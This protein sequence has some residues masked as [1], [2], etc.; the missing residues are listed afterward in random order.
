MVLRLSGASNV[1]GGG[2]MT[3]SFNWENPSGTVPAANSVTVAQLNMW[4]HIVG[5]WDGT[6][7]TIYVN[8]VA[9]GTNNTAQSRANVGGNTAIGRPGSYTG[10]L[11]FPGVIDDVRIYNRA[12]TAAEVTRLYNLGTATIRQN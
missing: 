6:T 5:T 2:A 3:F 4:Y 12:L 10:G 1:G 11:Y 9:E 8:G 7:R